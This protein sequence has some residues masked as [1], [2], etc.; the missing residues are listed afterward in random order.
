MSLF[1]VV[2]LHSFRSTTLHSCKAIIL[3]FCGINHTP[4]VFQYLIFNASGSKCEFQPITSFYHKNTLCLSPFFL[5]CHKAICI[6]KLCKYLFKPAKIKCG[7]CANISCIQCCAGCGYMALMM[8]I[9][10]VAFSH[11]IFVNL[12]ILFKLNMQIN[13]IQH[14]VCC[15]IIS[16][17]AILRIRSYSHNYKH[18]RTRTHTRTHYSAMQIRINNTNFVIFAVE[19]LLIGHYTF[20]FRWKKLKKKELCLV[21]IHA[22]TNGYLRNYCV[23]IR[24]Y[25]VCT[26]KI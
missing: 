8:L 13:S 3:H 20:S 7:M 4:Q 10:I 17:Q 2:Y 6:Q 19:M 23:Y 25:A 21:V 12:T 1:L 18:T 9:N 26:Y 22:R 5:L 15:I 16:F 11:K 14:L 24:V